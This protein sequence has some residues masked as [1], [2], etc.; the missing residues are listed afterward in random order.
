LTKGQAKAS[1]AVAV[2]REVREAPG[3]TQVLAVDEPA[4]A[5]QHTQLASIGRTVAIVAIV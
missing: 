1:E 5:T 4:A 2:A 3:G